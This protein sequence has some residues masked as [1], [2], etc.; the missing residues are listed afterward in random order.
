MSPRFCAM[1][2]EIWSLAIPRYYQKRFEQAKYA[3]LAAVLDCSGHWSGDGHD[4]F[5]S[6]ELRGMYIRR[7]YTHI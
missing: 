3:R 1:V 4:M 2:T 6:E 7:S 5:I